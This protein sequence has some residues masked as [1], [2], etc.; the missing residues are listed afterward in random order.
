M[1][2]KYVIQDFI[3]KP[4]LIHTLDIKKIKQYKKI[5]FNYVS[6]SFKKGTIDNFPIVKTLLSNELFI[7]SINED[8]EFC[9]AKNI[10][11]NKNNTKLTAQLYFDIFKINTNEFK[12]YQAGIYTYRIDF[13]H[14]AVS[15]KNISLIDYLLQRNHIAHNSYSVN[16]PLFE[17]Y[18]CLAY[19]KNKGFNF[20]PGAF[21]YNFDIESSPKKTKEVFNSLY[22]IDTLFEKNPNHPQYP[23][24]K[25]LLITILKDYLCSK[26]ENNFL[27]KNICFLIKKNDINYNNHSFFLNNKILNKNNWTLLKSTGFNIYNDPE[28]TPQYIFS[29]TEE[30]SLKN[31]NNFYNSFTQNEREIIAK[32]I[33]EKNNIFVHHFIKLD[34][35]QHMLLAQK[36]F[37]IIFSTSDKYLDFNIELRKKRI[38]N[39]SFWNDAIKSKDINIP[40]ILYTY[41]LYT[42]DYTESFN[43][44]NYDYNH[45]FNKDN[46]LEIMKYVS[47]FFYPRDPSCINNFFFNL[48][49]KLNIS[50][51]KILDTYSSIFIDYIPEEFKKIHNIYKEN[52]T[53]TQLINKDS[54]ISIEKKRL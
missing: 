17:D 52:K 5:L 6:S 15:C 29:L 35:A 10:F 16:T 23:L 21:R 41:N 43:S 18:E 42:H 27:F 45:F 54:T 26:E 37:N 1:G 4:D 2:N 38:T 9:I 51:D 34:D 8:E 12:N 44:T 28:K 46:L 33:K 20:N 47:Q 53:L 14:E 48:E 32:I 25:N 50:S 3:N 31:I 39:I 36:T 24:Y 30:Q 40:N 11:K 19:C 7:N 13:M 22:E 49:K